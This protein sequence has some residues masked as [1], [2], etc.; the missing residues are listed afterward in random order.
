MGI[1]SRFKTLKNIDTRLFIL[2][3]KV[4]EM[5]TKKQKKTDSDNRIF[6]DGVP[7]YQMEYVK[8]KLL[9]DKKGE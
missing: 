7:E 3:E 4:K 8:N 9:S 6:I 1:L 5:E 2:E